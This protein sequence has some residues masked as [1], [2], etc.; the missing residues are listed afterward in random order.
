MSRHYLNQSVDCKINA[1]FDILSYVSKN[2]IVP[3]PS[4]LQILR[5]PIRVNAQQDAPVLSLAQNA[6]IDVA[7]ASMEVDSDGNDTYLY[8]YNI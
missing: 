6:S 5:M 3:S 7:P 1:A 4:T 2:E 8:Q